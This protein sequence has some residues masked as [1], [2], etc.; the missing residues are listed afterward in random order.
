MSPTIRAND[1][2]IM[3]GFAFRFRSPQRGDIVAYRGNGISQLGQG[4]T[5]CCRIAGIPGDQLHLENGAIRING[6]IVSIT[7][8][9]GIISYDDP[10]QIPGQ[11]LFTSL[12]IPEGHYYLLGD[13]SSNSFDSRYWGTIP[14]GNIRGRMIF[15]L[16]SSDRFGRIK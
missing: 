10:I 9:E 1:R 3:E 16:T 11:E 5:Y 6:E 8:S 13:H 15:L 14:E 12:T 2:V 7:N 4:V